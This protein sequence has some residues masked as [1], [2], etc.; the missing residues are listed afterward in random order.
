MAGD[1]EVVAATTAF[2]MGIDKADVRSVVHWTLPASPEEY[3][4]QAGRAG[5]D[6]LPARC[7]LLYSPADKG[8]IV[9]FINRA[10]LSAGDLNG[11]HRA[12]ATVASPEGLFA[13]ADRE[14][15]GDEPRVALAVLERAGALELFPAPSG[16]VS[17]RLAAPRLSPKHVAAGMIAGRRVERQRWD[18]LKAIDA[19]ATTAGCR[20]KVLLEYFGDEPAARPDEVCCDGHASTVAPAIPGVDVSAAVLQA[21]DETNGVGR[22]IPA[23]GDPA[24]LRRQGAQERRPRPA[25]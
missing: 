9:Y 24:R 15:P 8:L 20:R 13:S 17:G 18:R 7:T 5:R 25:G 10:K 3:Y 16:H 22:S 6:G 19:Y 21:V 11:M 14:L 2:G 4:Q 23:H 1:L 12:L